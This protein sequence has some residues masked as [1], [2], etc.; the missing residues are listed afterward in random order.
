LTPICISSNWRKKH[1]SADF[2]DLR[3][4]RRPDE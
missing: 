1:L 3:A 2:R 4:K